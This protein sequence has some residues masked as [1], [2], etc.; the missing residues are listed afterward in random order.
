[1]APD[2]LLSPSTASTS[3]NSDESRST[4]QSRRPS[5]RGMVNRIRSPSNASQASTKS[6][7]LDFDEIDNWFQGFRKYNTLV[8]DISSSPEDRTADLAKASKALTKHCGG[9]FLH[10]LPESA[11]DF[12]LL[13]CPAGQ[14]S[15]KD[16]S[17]EPSWSWS[18]YNGPI[19]YPFDP[20][21]CPDIYTRPRSEGEWFRS[22]IVN[23]H[24]GPPATPYTV[25]REKCNSLRIK[26]PPYFHAPRGADAS[27]E[28]NTL[29][30]TASAISADGFEADQLHYEDKEIPVSRLLNEKGQ[31]CG[32]VMDF[33]SA[34]SQPSATGPYEFILLSR[35]L[36]RESDPELRRPSVA[37]MHPPG[38][39][40]WDGERFVWTAQVHDFD[41]GVFEDGEWK[42]LNVLLVRWVGEYAERVAVARIHEDEW[43]RR[44][45]VRKD[46]VL[47]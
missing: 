36:R 12:S 34:I 17:D 30:F 40:I 43:V 13:W 33:E 15:R 18:A 16:G 6:Q 41:E 38:T 47:R 1:M 3:S 29:R 45:P 28:S 27:V 7:T 37:T 46:V 2:G 9:R 19:N 10:S 39:P 5:L 11:F 31:H 8:T 4:R 44:G 42:M 21:T 35:N 25:R 22:E 14:L 23:F 20:T 32:V 24:V 26:Y